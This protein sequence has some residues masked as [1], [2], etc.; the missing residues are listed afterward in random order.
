MGDPR[1]V[2]TRAAA[3]PVHTV[4]YGDEPEQVIDLWPGGAGATLV[5]L[6]HGGFWRPAYDRMHLRPLAN[7]LAEAGFGVALPEYRRIGWPGMFG[8]VAAALDR[9]P[10]LIGPYGPVPGR[11]VWAGHSAGGHLALWGALRHRLP[12]DSPWHLPEPPA[13]DRVVA[14]AACSDLA[15]CAEWE[16]D[17]DAVE[18]MMGG[19]PADIPERYAV[20]DPV[21]LL[22]VT[23]PVVLLH[24]TEDDRV[25]IGVSRAFL[26]KAK[27][28]GTP[29]ESRE[30]PGLE[31]FALIDPLSPAWP[32]L[33]AALPG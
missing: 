32:Y 2:L 14:L 13:V 22:P 29:V 26:E 33:R 18:A 5:V 15:L 20:A 21:A 3:G 24:G 7:A 30:L 19:T 17:G 6:I 11:T 31:H 23:V 25:P 10:E 1:E 4:A 16:L 8:D 28:S 27:A 12:A 9:L